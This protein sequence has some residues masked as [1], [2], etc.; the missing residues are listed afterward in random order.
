MQYQYQ[1]VLSRII[2]LAEHCDCQVVKRDEY[3]DW[4]V[5][6]K[7]GKPGFFWL[8]GKQFYS[9]QL[10]ISM[11]IDEAEGTKTTQEI[12][13]Y[14]KMCDDSHQSLPKKED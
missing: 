5:N 1:P 8:T 12:D 6:R 7:N 14:F 13:A 4:Q 11:W 3:G 10:W 2:Q 9:E